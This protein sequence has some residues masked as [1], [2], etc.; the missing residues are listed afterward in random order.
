MVVVFLIFI[1]V[2]DEPEGERHTFINDVADWILARSNDPVE[3]DGAK[4]KL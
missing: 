2:H 4:S 1:I 3:V